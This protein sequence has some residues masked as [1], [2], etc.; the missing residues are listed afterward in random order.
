M[1][2]LELIVCQSVPT[3]SLEP[4]LPADQAAVGDDHPL[5]IDQR[6]HAEIPTQY[7]AVNKENPALGLDG[8]HIQPVLLTSRGF[9]RLKSCNAK[10]MPLIDSSSCATEAD[11]HNMREGIRKVQ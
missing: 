9:V 4:T 2:P 7:A 6:C 10:E 11:R 3:G 8:T 5:L 1:N